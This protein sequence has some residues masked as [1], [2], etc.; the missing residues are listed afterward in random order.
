MR[1]L[2]LLAC[3]ALFSLALVA[4][5]AI[6]DSQ[7]DI[8]AYATT[9]DA[10]KLTTAQIVDLVRKKVK[11]VFVIYQ[12]NRSFDSYFGTFPGA[13][14]I[15]SQPP[16]DTPGYYQPITD[17]NG[18]PDTVVPFLIGPSLYAADTD[19]LDHSHALLAR[20]I[21]VQSNGVAKMDLYAT[22]EEL[23]YSP[24]GNPSQKAKGY[25][26]LAMAH[27]D[28]NTIPF[29]WNYANRFVLFD[30]MFQDVDG[31]STPGN[32][33]IFA[34]QSGETQLALHPNEAVDSNY[35]SGAGEPVLN[36]DNP[37]NGSVN[38]PIQPPNV[39]RDPTD[40]A[41]GQQLNQ[42]YA[43][44]AVN[45][46]GK[47]MGKVADTDEN[48]ITDLAD[49]QDDIAYETKSGKASIPW[50]WYEEGYGVEVQNQDQ[51]GPVTSNGTHASYVTHHNG[52]QYFG[53]VAN[54]A[55]NQ[56][57]HSL[58]QFFATISADQL[59]KQGGLFYIKGG[60]HNLFG[61]TPQNPL[62]VVQTNFL[63]DDD[64]PAYSDAQISEALVAKAV[65]AIA[66]SPYWSQSAIIITWDDS[67]GDYDHVPPPIIRDDQG[68]P[69][70]PETF[71]PR[72][73]LML[74]SPYAKVHAIDSHVSSQSSVVKF[75]DEIFSRDP[76][77]TLPDEKKGIK[78]G[79]TEFSNKYEGPL[80]T[81]GG[82]SDLI[83][84]FD[85]NRLDGKSPVLP[86]SFAEIPD[87]VI[88]TLPHYNGVGC[89]VLG[90]VPEDQ[91]KGIVNTIPSDFNTLPGTSPNTIEPPPS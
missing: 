78:L 24:T 34:A 69:I 81:Y 88:Q 48:P 3:T 33:T 36:D 40:G 29:L 6:A 79:K 83:S 70:L 5:P 27:E 67:E 38:D 11:Y 71:G 49:I 53:Y 31:P 75:V 62:P 61:L 42:T 73:P 46:A 84:A 9:P 28:C 44:L 13:D 16:A 12:E 65:N 1:R 55:E 39:P 50:G 17:T 14:G 66:E 82:I 37:I 26:E 60:Y 80:D 91:A 85:P 86:P 25:G 20:K 57:L 18:A 56:N 10:T 52:P 8:A 64:H 22:E 21:D 59:P 89:A 15:Y 90:I 72:V 63:G 19:D 58:T 54:S 23:K 7:S 87:N 35:G 76:L 41:S 77:A 32:L 4:Q 43:T 30:H 51:S 74:V 47:T 68:N 2:S 45:L